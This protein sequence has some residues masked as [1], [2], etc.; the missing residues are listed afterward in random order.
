MEKE[1]ERNRRRERRGNKSERVVLCW[2][3][4]ECV[5]LTTCVC[6]CVWAG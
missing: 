3:D 4:G 2:A 1:E 5:G 6:V